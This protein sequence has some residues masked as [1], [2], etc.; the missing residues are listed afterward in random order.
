MWTVCWVEGKK[1]IDCWDRFE[2]EEEVIEH[3]KELDE[4]QSDEDYVYM[5]DVLV[6]PPN[7]VE[8]NGY[9]LLAAEGLKQPFDTL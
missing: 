1:M 7:D 5:E 8:T 6:I 2:S 4:R 3:L 9:E